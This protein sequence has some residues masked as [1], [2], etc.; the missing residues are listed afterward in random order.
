MN[1]Y[2]LF[3]SLLLITSC[4]PV[5]VSLNSNS[6]SSLQYSVK[7]GESKLVFNNS[8][9]EKITLKFE[10]EDTFTEDV[11]LSLT[12]ES[13]KYTSDQ[14][15][16]NFS[17]SFIITKNSKSFSWDLILQESLPTNE[18]IKFSLKI[19]DLNNKIKF[20]PDY[21]D[22]DFTLNFSAPQITLPSANSYINS[23]N[24]SAFQIQG[25]CSDDNSVLIYP[26]NHLSLSQTAICINNSFAVTLDLS[27][28]S[29][30]S[31]TI[32]AKQISTA[33][34][35][36]PIAQIIYLKDTFIPNVI[37]SSNSHT[38]KNNTSN[39]STFT[40][41]GTA[42]L[43]SASEDETTYTI[44][45]YSDNTCSNLLGN[46]TISADNFSFGVNLGTAEGEKNL[47]ARLVKQSGTLLP[48]TDLAFKYYFSKKEILIGGM[49]DTFNISSLKNIA[50]LTSDGTVISPG[51]FS[52]GTG[53]T[54]T[55]A[56]DFVRSIISFATKLLVVGNFD[57][58]NT[59]STPY[60]KF[61]Y[62]NG[63]GT[64]F[65]TLPEFNAQIKTVIT[66]SD[67]NLIFGGDFDFFSEVESQNLQRRFLLKMNPAGVVN[68][69]FT[70]N[71][72]AT[73]I[74]QT[75]A[76]GV[77]TIVVDS[78]DNLYVGGAIANHITKLSKNGIEDPTFLSNAG[79]GFDDVVYIIKI[80]SNG[81]LLIG[82]KFTTYN[83]ISCPKLAK[84]SK[85]GVLDT[86][87]CTNTASLF[88]D[89]V[90][91][92]EPLFNGQIAIGGKFTKGLK[93]LNSNGTEDGTFNI[94]TGFI[95]GPNP[96]I[97]YAI[98]QFVDGKL[99]IGGQFGTLD[100]ETFNGF[101]KLLPSGLPDTKFNGN[102]M[103]PTGQSIYTIFF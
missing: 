3:L 89:Y 54:H 88:N 63:I 26:K 7:N 47:S 45:I 13:Q 74:F 73:S 60:A 82:G 85:D 4:S 25:T 86:G 55:M 31:V 75:P 12:L 94:G 100:G 77:K 99:L 40:M 49:F 34:N 16:K 69:T 80:S 52:I 48:C 57:K 36:S 83:G 28:M 51:L 38:L 9:V 62:T 18:R 101:V 103:L 43:T 23:E 87:F 96:G 19:K 59:E 71:I 22:F 39:I 56:G 81:D 42:G 91:S 27:S 6:Y 67:N 72:L 17:Q 90:L 1:F 32:E 65:M 97:V 10:T 44:N 33:N 58:Y 15:F 8:M 20:T 14:L 35:E 68:N 53:F 5:D 37:I 78:L 92:I 29:D 70:S 30:G 84:L 93:I 24:K 76:T 79:V 95:D 21:F 64:N 102:G 11:S 50:K 46:T 61:I 98:R 41:S 2:I 66:D